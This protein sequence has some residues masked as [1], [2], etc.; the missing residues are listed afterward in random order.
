MKV[1]KWTN[2]KQKTQR[3]VQVIDRKYQVMKVKEWTNLKQKNQ[4]V[5]QV[6]DRKY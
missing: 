2:L 3:V 1:K 5:V 4:R 6:T